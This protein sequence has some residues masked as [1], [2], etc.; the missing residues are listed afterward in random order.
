MVSAEQKLANLEAAFDILAKIPKQ[1]FYPRLDHWYGRNICDPRE[2]PH[3]CETL[4]CAAGWLA[5]SEKFRSVIDLE[6][7]FT[8][9][10]DCPGV[11]FD[12]LF[13]RRWDFCAGYDKE[14]PLSGTDKQLAL[15]RIRREMGESHIV[16]LENVMIV[17]QRVA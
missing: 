9:P 5:L 11:I 1:R 6:H 12:C 16:A 17:E 7:S 3:D 13:S 15:Y 4:A 2:N 8:G 14:F 10:G